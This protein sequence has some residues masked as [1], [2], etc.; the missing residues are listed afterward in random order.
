MTFGRR[1]RDERRARGF[2]QHALA[3]ATGLTRDAISKIER[4][5]RSPRLETLVLLS[6]GLGVTPGEIADWVPSKKH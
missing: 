1:F 6:R 5:K 2:S 3:Q 4:G